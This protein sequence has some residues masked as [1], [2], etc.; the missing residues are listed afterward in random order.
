[1]KIVTSQYEIYVPRYICGTTNHVLVRLTLLH[2]RV[3]VDI[4]KEPLLNMAVEVL[5]NWPILPDKCSITLSLSDILLSIIER[6]IDMVESWRFE[7]QTGESNE[8]VSD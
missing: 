8:G 2:D 6:N 3:D 1:M 5:S 7:R 4:K